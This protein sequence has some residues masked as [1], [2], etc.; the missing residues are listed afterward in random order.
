MQVLTRAAPSWRVR[1]GHAPWRNDAQCT[2]RPLDFV[3]RNRL[4]P[5]AREMRAQPTESER[6]LWLAVRSGQLGVRFRR[7]VILGPFIVDLFVPAARLVIEVDGGVHRSRRDYDRL[8]DEW[9]RR[10]GLRVLRI[11]ADLVERDLGAAVA[12]VRAALAEAA[13]R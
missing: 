8:R 4:A 12:A 2:G 11:N 5:R 3:A 1:P 6:T 7:Q 13:A 9:L 10:Q